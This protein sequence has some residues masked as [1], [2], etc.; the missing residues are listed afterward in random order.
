MSYTHNVAFLS[1]TSYRHSYHSAF[2][3]PPRITGTSTESIAQS[4]SRIHPLR[5]S[6][7]RK[8]T[9]CFNPSLDQF[10]KSSS[11][12]RRNLQ[13]SSS[14]RP[15]PHKTGFTNIRSA[16]YTPTQPIHSP[17][18]RMLECTNQ[19][20]LIVLPCFFHRHSFLPQPRPP[21]APNSYHSTYLDPASYS[22]LYSL[23]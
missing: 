7:R 9:K 5:P 3:H 2:I 22:F 13:H 12:P 23:P 17:R 14:G 4:Y 6:N 15:S 19:A 10:F 1:H 21:F 8:N 20:L 18:T 11:T 16:N